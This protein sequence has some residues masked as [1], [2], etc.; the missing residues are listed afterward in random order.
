MKQQFHGRT[1]FKIVLILILLATLLKL[2]VVFNTYAIST[3]SARFIYMAREIKAGQ[4]DQAIAREYHLLMPLTMA[5]ISSAIGVDCETAGTIIAVLLGALTVLP[6]YYIGNKLFGRMAAIFGALL[7]S[8]HFYIMRET[9]DIMSDGM[10]IFFVFMALWFCLWALHSGRLWLLLICGVCVGCAYNAR[11]EGLGAGVVAG[12]F[13]LL[14]RRFGWSFGR[15]V[16]GVGCVL[17]MTLVVMAPYVMKISDTPAGFNLSLTPKKSVAHMLGLSDPVIEV[18]LPANE[19]NGQEIMSAEKERHS[20]MCQ[21]LATLRVWVYVNSGALI[22][23]VIGVLFAAIKRPKIPAGTALIVGAGLFF[24]AL[25]MLLAINVYNNGLPSKR[26]LMLSAAMLL[27]I[28]GAGLAVVCGWLVRRIRRKMS[29]RT[30]LIV[31][32]AVCALAPISMAILGARPRREEQTIQRVAGDYI[33]EDA[34]KQGIENPIVMSTNEKVA[35]YA[36]CSAD[37]LVGFPNTKVGGDWDYAKI[38]NY[39]RRNNVDFIVV[40]DEEIAAFPFMAH[41]KVGD[42]L[43]FVCYVDADDARWKKRF[44]LDIELEAED[45]MTVYRVK[46]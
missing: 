15:K 11:P 16:L 18:Q 9:A 46:K 43:A 7:W 27:P 28:A 37:S 32:L 26:H 31:A 22:L 12:A 23:V 40:T 1:D 36:E 30:A 19:N 29:A 20:A 45:K 33:C 5:G 13:I 17:L 10:H 4:I 3:D 2:V 44:G 34:K 6:I 39:A 35:Y 21:I 8:S 38:L 14:S 24:L 25:V 42:E 41:D